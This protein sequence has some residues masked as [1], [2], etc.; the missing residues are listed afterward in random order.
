MDARAT[1]VSLEP[2][3]GGRF[4]EHWGD[5][6]GQ[7]IATVTGLEPDRHLRLTGAFHFGL[8]LADATFDLED[9]PGG[10]L[11]RFSFR[12]VGAI[13]TA[14]IESIESGWTTLVA[15]RLKALVEAGSAEGGAAGESNLR[16]I[17]EPRAPTARSG[18][19]RRK[20]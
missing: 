2:G 3:L 16:V 4:L 17:G 19:R 18:S 15:S 13:D 8:A 10:T 6:G 12:A 20:P 7:M 1:G 11:L 5:S 9:A 14:A